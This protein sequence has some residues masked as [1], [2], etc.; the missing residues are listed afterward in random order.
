MRAAGFVPP[1]NFA[2]GLQATVDFFK[3]KPA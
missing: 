3:G 2:E 1:G